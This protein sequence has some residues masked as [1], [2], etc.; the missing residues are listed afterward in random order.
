MQ[1]Q[2]D[3][4]ISCKVVSPLKSGGKKYGIG[5]IVELPVDEAMKLYEL[6][7]VA[8][9]D[10]VV[11]ASEEPNQGK[12]EAMGGGQPNQPPET[13]DQG[14]L[15]VSDDGQPKQPP[16]ATDQG[17]PEETEIPEELNAGN[18]SVADTDEA[19]GGA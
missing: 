19:A 3:K 17:K 6:G 5:A 2:S 13:T 14:K 9:P 4:L 7:V 16:E 1:Q 18:S 8:E 12:S 11:I 10:P 15:G